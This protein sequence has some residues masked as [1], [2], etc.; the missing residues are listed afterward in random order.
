[1]MTLVELGELKTCCN[2]I[3]GPPAWMEGSCGF[4][5]LHCHN[6]YV[7]KTNVYEYYFV[8]T[9]TPVLLLS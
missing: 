1:M 4:G 9:T 7:V 2:V 5:N 6:F 8:L 3:A